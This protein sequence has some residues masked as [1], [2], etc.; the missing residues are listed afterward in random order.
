ML[1]L[2]LGIVLF[3]GMHSA[4]ILA[5]PMR[6]RIAARSELGWKAVYAIVSLLGI[7]LIVRGYADLRQVPTVLYVPPMWLRHV[8]AM[9][10]NPFAIQIAMWTTGMS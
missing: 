9:I 2:L 5:L 10:S 8:A 4:S 7:I 6:D 3:F 1:Q